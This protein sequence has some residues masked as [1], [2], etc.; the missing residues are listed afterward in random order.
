MPRRL[1][2]IRVNPLSRL[3]INVRVSGTRNRTT[4]L[5]MPR[6]FTLIARARIR[7]NRHGAIQNLFRQLRTIL[8]HQH[9]T[10][11]LK[12]HRSRTHT[13]RT[14][15]TRTAT[16]LI[17]NDRAGT[18][19]ILSGRSNDVKRISTRLSRHDQ[20]RRIG[21]TALRNVSSPVLL[22]HQRATIGTLSNG[23][24]RHGARSIRLNYHVI[25]QRKS[26]RTTLI[27]TNGAKRI[28]RLVNQVTQLR[29]QTGRMNLLALFVHLT[30]NT[31]NRITTQLNR[32][33]YNRANA[34]GEPI[35]SSTHVRVP[36]SQGHRHA[37]S[38]HYHRGR[39]VNAKTLHTRNIT[40]T[41]AGTILL[42][43]SRRQRVLGHRIVQGSHINTGRSVRLT[44]FRLN[45]S[46]LTL[47]HQHNTHRR[48]PNRADL[49]R[50]KTNL[51]NVLAH[52]RTHKHRGTNLHTTVNDRD[53]HTNNGD[54]LTNA[55]VTRRRTIRRTPTVTRVTR[56]VLRHNLLLITRQGQRNLLGHNRILTHNINV[57][58]RVS[59]TTIITRTRHRLRMRTLLMNGP[60]THSVTLDRTQKGVSQSGHANVTRRTTLSTRTY[61]GQVRKVTSSLRHT[62]CSTTR[63]HLTRTIARVVSQRGNTHDAPLVRLFGIQ[64]NRLLGA[65]NGLGLTRRNRTITLLGLLN[66]P[67]LARGNSLRRTHLVGR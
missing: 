24:Q 42:V 1:S 56:S 41:R 7:L 39:R 29:R 28:F 58:C 18:L 32:R 12:I 67:E 21:L 16:R 46:P 63:P 2:H 31:V 53:R 57:K 61:K 3:L 37:Q 50:R 33:I 47:N 5:T 55:S 20:S 45:V 65:M 9:T 11:T 59:R 10:I 25:G 60:Y 64:Q 23:P 51:V 40:L 35:T 4:I 8:Y 15:A 34:Q 26:H 6:S 30:G 19:T 36:M 22:P 44:Q 62:A 13:Q 38:K 49:Q 43:S 48:H 66:G 52:R 27:I 14:T 54:N 17:R